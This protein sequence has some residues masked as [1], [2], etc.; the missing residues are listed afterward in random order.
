[1][2]DPQDQRQQ[3]SNSNEVLQVTLDHAV[4]VSSKAAC[5]RLTVEF[6]ARLVLVCNFVPFHTCFF[7]T[8]GLLDADSVA[9][10][11]HSSTSIRNTAG[12]SG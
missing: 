3:G 5:K 11:A 7:S 6:V 9:S 4:K 12:H 8:I 10:R 1:L 2:A